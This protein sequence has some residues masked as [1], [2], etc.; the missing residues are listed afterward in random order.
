MM[1]FSFYGQASLGLCV[2]Q[3]SCI[4]KIC[5]VL[6]P[7]PA[8]FLWLCTVSA[9]HQEPG[10]GFPSSGAL[11]CAALRCAASQVPILGAWGAQQAAGSTHASIAALSLHWELC[12][13]HLCVSTYRS[14]LLGCPAL[15]AQP[16]AGTQ[17]WELKPKPPQGRNPFLIVWKCPV[18]F[19]QRQTTVDGQASPQWLK[20]CSCLVAEGRCVILEKSSRHSGKA[21]R[22]SGENITH[23]W[24]YCLAPKDVTTEKCWQ[25]SLAREAKWKPKRVCACREEGFS[26]IFFHFSHS[27][28]SLFHYS[29]KGVTVSQAMTSISCRSLPLIMSLCCTHFLSGHTVVLTTVI[30]SRIDTLS[31]WKFALHPLLNSLVCENHLLNTS[32]L[33]HLLISPF[34]FRSSHSVLWIYLLQCG[35]CAYLLFWISKAFPYL[36]HLFLWT[37]WLWLVCLSG[38]CNVTWRQCY[39]STPKKQWKES[40]TISRMPRTPLQELESSAAPY[41]L[42]LAKTSAAS[43]GKGHGWCATEKKREGSVWFNFVC[44]EAAKDREWL[45]RFGREATG[46]RR[47]F[48]QELY[49]ESVIGRITNLLWASWWIDLWDIRQKQG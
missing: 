49:E 48:V 26:D 47:G 22:H 11:Q 25:D 9:L 42:C 31:G 24:L 10:H 1:Q 37:I 29:Q 34:S 32:L 6:R 41:H 8:A 36:I 4:C 39:R 19:A 35:F 38:G 15:P 43:G 44:V 28:V 2:V 5:V 7:L 40:C 13:H 30:V 20:G 14:C 21:S 16:W 18:F 23:F 17:V 46:T 3:N 45:D 12:M 33:L 27:Q